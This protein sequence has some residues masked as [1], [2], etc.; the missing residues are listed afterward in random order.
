MRH[1]WQDSSEA[2]WKEVP[3]KTRYLRSSGG[4]VRVQA[5]QKHE[6]YLRTFRCVA[7]DEVLR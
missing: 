2:F 6:G 3:H 7:A 4:M 5:S 1:T